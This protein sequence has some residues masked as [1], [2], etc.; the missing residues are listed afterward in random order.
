MRPGKSGKISV[1]AVELKR[2]LFK[3]LRETLQPY[4]GDP[5]AARV[6]E[7]EMAAHIDEI[8]K[9]V[10]AAPTLYF[11]DPFGVKGLKAATYPTMLA[12]GHNEI[13]AL[14]SDIGAVRLR[15]VVHGQDRNEAKIH[16][17]LQNRSLFPDMIE[18]EVAGLREE[19]A[20][21]AEARATF[22]PAAKQAISDALGDDSWEIDLADVPAEEAREQI[23]L[24]FAGKMVAAGALYWNIIPIRDAGGAYKYLLMHFTKSVSGYTTMK[25]SVEAALNR[26]DLSET[27]RDSIREDLRLS[28]PYILGRLRGEFSGRTVRWSDSKDNGARTVRSFLLEETDTFPFQCKEIQRIL[29]A[30]GILIR[31]KFDVCEFPPSSDR[32]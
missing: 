2:A 11:L 32:S 16:S 30:D 28:V 24:R 7:G 27:M 4:L 14:F 29:R 8:G 1:I 15:G 18:E 31:Q 21:K 26:N 23:V 9:I 5:Q 6:Y 20:R 10:G 13:F 3:S 25:E 17:L 22:A 12:G 19:S